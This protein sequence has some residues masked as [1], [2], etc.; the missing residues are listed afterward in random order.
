M[1][2]VITP[3]NR[4]LYTEAIED[5]YRMRFHV[6]VKELGWLLPDQAGGYDKDK[7]DKDDTIYFLHHNEGGE[8]IATARL[9]PTT[10]GHLMTDIFSEL[11]EFTGVPSG[12]HIFE[13]SRFLVK[14]ENV[15]RRDNLTAQAYISLAVVEYCL[16]AEITH[17]TWVSYKRS[18]PLALRMW[19]TRPLG[20][21][22]YFEADKS[23][24]IAA[25][26]EMSEESL[27]RTRD[28]A[29][30]KRPVCQITV[31]L[32]AAPDLTRL[33]PASPPLFG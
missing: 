4:H 11:C 3:A 7:Y 2:H 21:P 18:Y 25:I 20:L 9:N 14:K 8:I 19:K 22:Q 13:Y 31:P 27:R 10:R 23:D 1:V 33:T 32:E 30:V 26:S 28:L 5:M 12:E 29:R 15:S 17:V 24:Y 16:A 6:A